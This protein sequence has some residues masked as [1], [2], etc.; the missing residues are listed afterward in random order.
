MVGGRLV[1]SFWDSCSSHVLMSSRLAAELILM[2]NKWKRDLYIP[3]RQGSIWTGAITTRVWADLTIVHKGREIV[4]PN[5]QFHVWDMGRDVTLSCAFMDAYRLNDW[6]GNVED[7]DQLRRHATTTGSWTS[8]GELDSTRAHVAGERGGAP[9]QGGRG[10][11]QGMVATT[12]AD[13]G[14][15]NAAPRNLA[16]TTN[17]HDSWTR[18]KAEALRDRLRQQLREPIPQLQARLEAAAD[19]FPAAFGEDVSEPC[20]LK[21]FKIKLKSG[22]Q[23]VAMVPR[24]LSAPMLE[25][26][27]KQMAA[28]LAQGVIRPSSSAWAFPLVLVR[29]PGSDKVRCCVDFRLLNEMTEPYPYGMQDLHMTLDE[30]AGKRYYWSVDVSSYYHQIK[31]DDS[32]CQ[33]TA[34]VLPGGSKYEYTRV[35]FGLRSAPAWAQQQLRE[36]LQQNEG[37]KK[38]IN[39]LDD[40]TYGSDDIEDSVRTFRELLKFC[41]ENRIKLKRSKCT[42]GVGAVKALGFVVN[43]QG[44]W[45]DPE[46]VLSLL[47]IPRAQSPKE[48]KQLLGSFGFVRQF[49]A[50]SAKTCDPLF[51]LLKK[52]AKFCWT[53]QHDAALEKL[54]EAVATAPCLG[55]IDPKKP[56]YAKVDAS[57][58]G[59]A[60]VLYQMITEDGTEVPKAIAY[61][62]RRF[63]PT[64]RRWC[65]AEKE[66]YSQKFVWE[67]FHSLL[68]GLP[69][70]IETDHRNHLYMYSASSLKLQ[71]WRMYLEQFTYDVRHVDGVRNATADGMSRIFEDLSSL[72]IAN[73]MATAPTD[74]QARRERE[75][76]IIA[77]STR[78]VCQQQLE[79]SKDVQQVDEIPEGPDGSGGADEALFAGLYAGDGLRLPELGPECE[80]K[81]GVFA[82]FCANEVG[83]EEEYDQ[84]VQAQSE[85]ASFEE[86]QEQPDQGEAL[87]PEVGENE[88]VKQKIRESR[89]QSR[90][91]IGYKLLESMGWA[92]GVGI[93]SSCACWND[94][95]EGQN[96]GRAVGDTRGLGMVDT[97]RVAAQARPSEEL[98]KRKI[99]QVHNSVAGH[100]GAVRTY[101]RL[102][103]LP[104]FPWGMKTA[105]IHAGVRKWCESCL[106]CNKVWRLR[107]DPQRAQAAV[108]RQRPFTE[109]AMDLI[110][111][112]EPDID[113]NRN[114]LVLIDS[115][116]RAVELYPLK[117]GDAES[118]V[119]C[120]F[121]CYTRWGQPM[122][123]RCDGAKAFLGS[124]CKYF[125]R[126]MKV[127]VKSIEPYS[128]YQNGQVERSNQEI[129]RHL[130]AMIVSEESGPNSQWRWGL[131]AAAARR[132]INNTVNWETGVTP[133]ELLY[134]GFA[135]TELSLFGS[136]PAVGAGQ[137]VPGWALAK[138]L[139]DA[140]AELLRRSE[141]YQEEL[142][143]KVQLA[144]AA[145][146]LREIHEGEWVLVK[147]GGLSQRPKSKLQCRY[148]GPYLVLERPDPTS[149]IVS[150]QH[151]A[152]KSVCKFHMSELQ[153]VKLENYQTVSDAIP[154]ALRDE[155]TYLIDSIVAHRPAGRRRLASGK[156]RPKGQYDFFVKYALL[157]ES[158]E[159]GEEN[160]CWQ[161][162]VNCQ[163]LAALRDYCAKPEVVRDLGTNFYV[164][165]G[166]D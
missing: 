86:V 113:G 164:S 128:P 43:S 9:P 149:S 130:R 116:S 88:E 34:F 58:V 142:L 12:A 7:D 160:P 28:L 72:H 27:Q 23:Y 165:D 129:M 92:T 61:A 80:E 125:N 112:K 82:T 53:V 78:V 109:V 77:P 51:D 158:T 31:L 123:L 25:E 150:C 138:E 17:R 16:A 73:L 68:Q 49:L 38:L 20:L 107:G 121:D 55:Q 74:E 48:L 163:H 100:M 83:N 41:V 35:P 32:S 139:E 4:L 3:M 115:F 79:L 5:F 147:R 103:K 118:V 45:I 62:S 159:V 1:A 18:E 81:T 127:K 153:A 29:R 132:I 33:Y 106:I 156:L 117:T 146:G 104:E 14:S 56:V 154:V 44:K 162:W 84:M 66:G 57:D 54:K 37:T 40:I 47:K 155:W 30:L 60:C 157:P 161:P 21:P 75:Q 166:D 122:Q 90:Y 145:A 76:G 119:E 67:R 91:G 144:A 6:R 126:M 26:V 143:T 135:D 111:V 19:E 42:L 87:D 99:Q 148:M 102:R 64:E 134:G 114:I 8:Q 105:D 11:F 152:T 46:R 52:N 85:G 24:R 71:R 89:D 15:D 2:G 36:K 96:R 59:C 50:D 94:V 13:G 124:V 69:V 151:L 10:I 110:V 133:N 108:I 63:S 141:L 137:S 136:H 70:V 22:A 97:D 65:L 120:L 39:F 131:L 93:G 140:Q 101:R 98:L 95:L